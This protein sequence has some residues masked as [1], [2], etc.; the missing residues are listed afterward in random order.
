MKT[1][2][3][4][5]LMAGLSFNALAIEN[6][7]SVNWNNYDDIVK[8]YSTD[9]IQNCSG[10]LLAGKFILT[11]AHCLTHENPTVKVKSATGHLLDIIA[12]NTHTDF[13][14]FNG[15][16]HDVAVSELNQPIDAKA[17]H[18]FADLTKDTV[19]ESDALRVFGFGETAEQLNY[20]DFTMTDLGR[21]PQ[22][23]LDGKVI[24]ND[25]GSVVGGN[26]IGGDSGGAWLDNNAIVATHKGG[27]G[28]G[29]GR[30]TYSTNLHYSNQFI[31]DTVNGWHYPTLAN[32]SNGSATITVQSLH[33]NP[34][35]DTA[36]YSGD[37]IITGGTCLGITDIQPFQT[38]TYTIESQGGTGT[39]HLSDSESITINKPAPT[40]ESSGGGDSGG[41]LG[42]LSLI[43]LLGLGFI[44][45]NKYEI[46]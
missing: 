11:A 42:F 30:V 32:T 29:T 5:L 26:T 24:T 43:G 7:T 6:G 17:I 1:T 28:E 44:R 34:Y 31:L 37:V 46:L 45:K 36:D 14:V 19:K 39:L 27:H 35:S 8:L 33:I 15:N 3:I 4:A 10:T 13:D 9:N 40:T 12:D 23:R 41:S 2:N 38:C 22:D 21:N 25:T 18:F 16:W 20:A